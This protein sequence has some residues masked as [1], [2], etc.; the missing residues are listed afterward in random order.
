MYCNK[1]FI[2]QEVNLTD[3]LWAIE[4]IGYNATDPR[5]DGYYQFGQKQKLYEILWAVESQLKKCSA[6]Y[7]EDAWLEEHQ[8]EVIINKLKGR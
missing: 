2:L 1:E 3:T 7:G 4:M 8:Q 6:F 5:M